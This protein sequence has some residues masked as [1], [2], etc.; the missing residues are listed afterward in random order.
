KIIAGIEE[1]QKLAG[2][3]KREFKVAEINQELAAKIDKAF[4]KDLA[5]ALDTKKYGKIE[6][7]AK[8]DELHA[9]AV[10]LIASEGGDD[11]AK[12]EAGSLF[13]R[14]K[15]RIFR[16]EILKSK[17]RPDGRKFNEIRQ[18]TLEST[19]LPRAHGSSLFTRG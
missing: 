11:A 4:R 1:L 3:T 7:Y 6:S 12:S 16:D 9:K 15:E 5:D 2:K 10:E 14:L 8:V 13:D 17:R 19:V 18:I